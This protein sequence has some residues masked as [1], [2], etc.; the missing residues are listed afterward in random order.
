MDYINNGLS[1][2]LGGDG[3]LNFTLAYA[4][5]TNI[6]APLIYDP[7]VKKLQIAD[8][9]Y[10]AREDIQSLQM[11]GLHGENDTNAGVDQVVQTEKMSQQ[12][13]LFEFFRA[14]ANLKI[15]VPQQRL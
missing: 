3:I 10:D 5:I 12:T 14:L 11:S 6:R 8:S 13:F 9:D 2:F 1:V 15:S 7:I 4:Q